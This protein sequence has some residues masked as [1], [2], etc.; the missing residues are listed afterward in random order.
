MERLEPYLKK[1]VPIKPLK[2]FVSTV[3]YLRPATE[4][5]SIVTKFTTIENASKTIKH[6]KP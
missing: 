6:G 1:T 2:N 3:S 5:K 4:S